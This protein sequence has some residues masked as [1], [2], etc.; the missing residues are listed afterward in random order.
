M[1]FDCRNQDKL[2]YAAR[3]GLGPIFVCIYSFALL[4]LSLNGMPETRTRL[5]TIQYRPAIALPSDNTSLKPTKESRPAF[6]SF[7]C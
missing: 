5:L 3:R 7:P 1:F 6:F 2:E 4:P